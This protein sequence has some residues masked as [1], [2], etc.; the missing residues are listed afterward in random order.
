MSRIASDLIY[1]LRQCAAEMGNLQNAGLV[2]RWA[3]A[4]EREIGK[5]ELPVD[6][7]MSHQ[8][9]EEANG[10]SAEMLNLQRGNP[11]DSFV[12]QGFNFRLLTE[13]NPLIRKEGDLFATLAV[14]F[15]DQDWQPHQHLL[16]F[17][18]KANYSFCVVLCSG[19]DLRER[20]P[21]YTPYKGTVTLPA[22]VWKGKTLSSILNERL[23]E[24]VL[25]LAKDKVVLSSVAPLAQLI[26]D[27][28]NHE[29][30][31]I[32][33]RRTIMSQQ[34][35][36]LKKVEAVLNI[37]DISS[38]FR[39]MIQQICSEIEREIKLKYDDLNRPVTGAFSNK[40]VDSAASINDLDR[41]AV[42]EK[43]EKAAL[44]IGEKEL[45]SILN[46]VVKDLQT[47]FDRDAIAINKRTSALASEINA[48]VAMK[49]PT[50]PRIEAEKV[51]IDP[52]RTLNSFGVYNKYYVGE[53]VK[54]GVMEYFVSVRDYVGL[55]MVFS[56]LIMPIV[57]G[58]QAM[59][60]FSEIRRQQNTVTIRQYNNK[61][62]GGEV[63]RGGEVQVLEG[64]YYTEDLRPVTVNY[65]GKIEHIGDKVKPKPSPRVYIIIAVSIATMGLMV[66]GIFD[67]RKRIPAKR[68]EEFE[69]ELNKARELIGNE[70]KRI[71]ADS[72]RD[73][74]TSISTWIRDYQNNLL[75]RIERLLK[76][77]SAKVALSLAAH[78]AEAQK[79][80]LGVEN[81]QRR[82]TGVQA[83]RDQLITRMRE[84]QQENEK[85]VSA[86]QLVA[87]GTTTSV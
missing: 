63:V 45:D 47:E 54:K 51:P 72:S 59:E 11:G 81:A 27:S 32:S 23:N 41:K 55:V 75:N 74:S 21:F 31:L 80:T 42:A 22:E 8:L 40:C 7:Y 35:N 67:L 13:K 5:P 78:R 76:E 77:E 46:N 58:L 33:V 14:L 20:S 52:S 85:A 69:R 60:Q 38:Q 50:A 39:T 30:Q 84:F 61:D 36:W 66:F 37:N 26:G 73:W 12:E 19:S 70:T 29:N 64:T 83:L 17:F 9:L 87:A 57:M 68:R 2:K 10:P 16:Q 28:M 62:I 4:I 15:L 6:V 18:K 25:S 53:M 48:K 24:G 44:S 43:A 71:F 49:F 3:E 79:M 1:R 82:I 56:G 34:A 65:L 86:V